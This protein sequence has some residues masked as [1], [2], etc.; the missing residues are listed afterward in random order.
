MTDQEKYISLRLKQARRQEF[1]WKELFIVAVI[2][3]LCGL[4]TR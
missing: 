3:V 4:L 2:V 1:P